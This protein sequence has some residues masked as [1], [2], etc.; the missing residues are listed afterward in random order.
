[1]IGLRELGLGPIA[2]T[3]FL[4]GCHARRESP[5]RD[6]PSLTSAVDPRATLSFRF[7][8]REVHRLSLAE[9]EHTVATETV[10]TLDG[11]YHRVKRFRAL[12]LASVLSAGFAGAA[13]GPLSQQQFIL[14]ARDGYTVPIAGQ[15]LLSGGAYLAVRDLDHPHWEPIGPQRANPGPI[16]LIWSRPDQTDLETHPRPW[17]LA[18]IEIARFEDIFPHTVPTGLPP[19]HPA[20]HGYSLFKTLC[21]RC[22]AINRE[23]GRVG[24]DLN[25]P[26]SIVEYRPVAQIRAYISNPL[27]FRYGTMPAHPSLTPADLDNLIAYFTA[28]RDR[29]NDPDAHPQPPPRHRTLPPETDP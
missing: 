29:K 24:P 21:V 22:H 17:Q 19:D 13:T 4:S 12:P 14:R 20:L 16:Y 18:S 26:L 15:E 27:A 9:L 1:M 25:V 2:L 10:A 3:V 8:N 28:M 11:Y 23:G 5:S 7:E 6:A